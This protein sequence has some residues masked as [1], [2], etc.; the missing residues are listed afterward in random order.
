MSKLLLAA[1][2]I[3]VILVSGCASSAPQRTTQTHGPFTIDCKL[4]GPSSN[5]NLACKSTGDC[6]SNPNG[7]ASGCAYFCWNK[8]EGSEV[9]A[10]TGHAEGVFGTSIKCECSCRTS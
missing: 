7:M 2:I 4:P 1:L 8:F 5:P 6:S 10:A 3:A 9:A